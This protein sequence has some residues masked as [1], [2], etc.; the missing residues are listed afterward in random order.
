SNLANARTTRTPEGGP[1]L[2]R[3][4][5][6]AAETLEGKSF[7]EML[8]NSVRAVRVKGVITDSRPPV[9]RY[10]PGHP[11]ANEQGYVAYPNVDPVEEIVDMLS[12]VRSYEANVNVV[13]IIGKMNEAAMRIS[14]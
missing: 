13:K 12:A 5:V 9:M 4:P 6:V 11:D 2:R 7:G 14:R 3:L 8:D 1:Y 10:E